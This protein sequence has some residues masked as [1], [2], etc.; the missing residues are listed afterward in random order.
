M[1]LFGV[2]LVHLVDRP[3]FQRVLPR[4]VLYAVILLGIVPNLLAVTHY[5]I[6]YELTPAEILKRHFH[7]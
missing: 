2:G 6:S 3:A 4:C 7:P 5:D 1:P